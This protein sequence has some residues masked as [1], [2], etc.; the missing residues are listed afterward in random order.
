MARQNVRID[1]LL[2]THVWE[3]GPTNRW[4]LSGAM[5]TNPWEGVGQVHE[6]KTKQLATCYKPPNHGIGGIII[7]PKNGAT[8]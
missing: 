3:P 2:A 7:P 4:G 5:G 8:R 1:I 6:L